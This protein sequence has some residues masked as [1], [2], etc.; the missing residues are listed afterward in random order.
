MRSI[1][2]LREA[3][4]VDENG[5]LVRPIEVEA[6]TGKESGV[7]TE[8]ETRHYTWHDHDGEKFISVENYNGLKLY[9]YLSDEDLNEIRVT[10]IMATENVKA[11]DL[12]GADEILSIDAAGAEEAELDS[13]QD[14]E[15]IGTLYEIEIVER[16]GYTRHIAI[17]CPSDWC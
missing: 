2:E 4:I 17:Y 12:L 8:W 6:I 13:L 1:E 14:P 10:G 5:N 9:D 16:S 3:E 7:W 15:T 11:V